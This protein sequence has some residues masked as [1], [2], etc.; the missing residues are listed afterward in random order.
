MKIWLIFRKIIAGCKRKLVNK[1]ALFIISVLVVVISSLTLI[2]YNNLQRESMANAISSTST[3][4]NLVNNDLQRYFMGIEQFTLPVNSYDDL[5]ESLRNESTEYDSQVFLED[6]IS[7]LFYQHTDISSIYLY[8]ISQKKYYYIYRSDI[9]GGVRI[10]YSAAVP[11]QTWYKTVMSDGGKFFEPI[12]SQPNTSYE[13]YGGILAFHRT[14]AAISDPSPLAVISIF[15]NQSGMGTILNEMPMQPDVHLLYLNSKNIPYYYDSKSFY[16]SLKNSDGLKDVIKATQSGLYTCKIGSEKYLV[17]YNILADGSGK[18]IEYTPYNLIY[19]PAVNN[20]NWN[21]IIGLLFLS[22]SV[23]IVIMITRA[24][25]KP[26]DSLSKEIIK[27]GEGDFNV[28]GEIKGQDE[29]AHLE[30]EF[31]KMVI[32]INDLINERYKMKLIEKNAILKA[33]EAEVN[34]HFLY[35]ALQAISTKALKLGATDIYDMVDTLALTFRYCISGVDIVKISDEIRHIENYLILQKERYGSRLHLEYDLDEDALMVKIPK[36]SIQTLVENSIKHALE[37]V[38]RDVTIVI[39]AHSQ[40]GGALISVGDN[41]PGI[42]Q[43]RLDHILFTL[44][45]D[46]ESYDIVNKSIGLKNLNSRLT[47]IYGSGSGIKI[48]TEDNGVVVSFF[49]PDDKK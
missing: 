15:F 7:T 39:H 33:L 29:I 44:V 18:L 10:A 16:D 17:V 21:L 4:L 28:G 41:G 37:K 1:L 32:K 31:N 27:F 2:S 22:I 45:H 46:E 36:L 49:V 6:Y 34:P 38:S 8:I 30:W 26:L 3:S 14:Y 24:I 25:T 42:E 9:F 12:Y 43:K 48:S 40:T 5:I 20:K 11:E 47:L 23:C 35:N 13:S 19:K